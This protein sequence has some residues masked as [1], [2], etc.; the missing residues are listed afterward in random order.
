MLSELVDVVLDACEMCGPCSG[1]TPGPSTWP[2]SVTSSWDAA[3]PSRPGR[4]DP[5]QHNPSR[6]EQDHS[7]RD[8]PFHEGPHQKERMEIDSATRTIFNLLWEMA[9]SVTKGLGKVI[10]PAVT[11]IDA[12]PAVTEGVPNVI[13]SDRIRE[14]R[15][16]EQTGGAMGTPP[17]GSGGS[18][19]SGDTG[20]KDWR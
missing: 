4:G 9:T 2:G 16:W 6:P 14:E 11:A 8:T 5:R 7:D 19:G 17:S 13:N 20:W 10:G 1:N 15:I 3:N 18:G 12:T